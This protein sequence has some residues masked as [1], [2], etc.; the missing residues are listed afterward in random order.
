MPGTP[1]SSP[2]FLSP[3]DHIFAQFNPCYYLYFRSA[4]PENV[5]SHL[6]RGLD[7]L[8]RQSPFIAGEIVRCEEDDTNPKGLLRIQQL[9]DDEDDTPILQFREDQT[10]SIDRISNAK[11]R[12]GIE[13]ALLAKRLAAMAMM[14]NPSQRQYVVRFVATI[15]SDGLILT[16]SFSHWAFD[17]T[18][19]ASLLQ[20]LAE[21][22]R[23]G[24]TT[25]NRLPD[26]G[27]RQEIWAMKSDVKYTAEHE[28]TL[29][30]PETSSPPPNDME[31]IVEGMV[32]NAMVWRWNIPAFKVALL[33]AACTSLLSDQRPEIDDP[34]VQY[35]SSLDVLTG[36]L[37]C[38]MQEAQGETAQKSGVGI[39]VNLRERLTPSFPPEYKGN[40]VTYATVN[41]PPPAT[42]YDV[43]WAQSL[44]EKKFPAFKLPAAD[45]T[46]IYRNASAVRSTILTFTDEYVRS[47]IA[48]LKSQQDL[49]QMRIKFPV[50]NFTSWRHLGIYDLDFG[51]PLGIVDDIQPHGFIPSCGLIM[52]KR[53][54]RLGKRTDSDT[55]WEVVLYL[56][57]EEYSRLRK[58]ELVRFLVDE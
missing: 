33:K 17:A 5:Q 13:D 50:M 4:C 46:S 49:D 39:P 22:C 37:T 19:A 34:S 30:P 26:K 36:Y 38:C 28:R 10:L 11:T 2:H 31:K 29:G 58:S 9:T 16:M 44:L 23:E 41:C 21:C 40:F 1:L 54:Q 8:L 51:A 25:S 56:T 43:A 14:P 42:A 7:K 47:F 18:G 6:Q 53:N 45:L 3:L 57:R 32:E 24:G 55:D 35:L 20:D 48:W 52:P 15:V 12:T 27:L